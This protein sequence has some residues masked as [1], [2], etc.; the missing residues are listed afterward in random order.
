MSQT[1]PTLIEAIVKTIVTHTVTYFIMGLLASTILD[2]TR[3]FAESSLNLIMRQTNDPWVM[4]GPLF[5]PIRGILFGVVFYLLRE[6]F[7]GKKNGWLLMWI[8]LVV[9][10][11]IGTF[12][13]TPGSLEGMLY[14]VFPLWVHLRGLPEVLLQSLFL[15]LILF[16]WVNHPQKKWLNWVMGIAFLILMSFPI[17]GLLVGQ[18]K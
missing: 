13:P 10:G 9:V 7:F 17:I 2:Y 18:P 3:F 8:V 1:R 11:I 15:S 5:Q 4:V 6:P 12:G 16:Y 14:T